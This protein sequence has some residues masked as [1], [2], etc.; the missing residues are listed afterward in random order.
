MVVIL[1]NNYETLKKTYYPNLG[2]PVAELSAYSFSIGVF[3]IALKSEEIIRFVPEN[4]M[5]FK[6]W[7][8]RYHIR[9]IDEE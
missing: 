2:Y 5:D 1:P 7:L 6:A 9:N 4:V 8:D 3:I